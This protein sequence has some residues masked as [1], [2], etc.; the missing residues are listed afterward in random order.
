V[1]F[2]GSYEIDRLP[3]GHNYAIYAE[4]LDGVVLPAQITPATA[5]LCRNVTTDAG[6]PP[7][8]GCVVPAVD[9]SFTVR[10]RPGS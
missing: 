5:S 4:P 1:Q 2:D 10:M 8:Q 6:W 7:L 3:V 9:T